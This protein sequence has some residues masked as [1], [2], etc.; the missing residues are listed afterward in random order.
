M[1]KTLCVAVCSRKSLLRLFCV[2]SIEFF[3]VSCVFFT[4]KF[5]LSSC[6]KVYNVQIN[7]EVCTVQ[8]EVRVCLLCIVQV[9]TY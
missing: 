3:K 7:V 2:K 4:L 5:V 8:L 9:I 1:I 6:V